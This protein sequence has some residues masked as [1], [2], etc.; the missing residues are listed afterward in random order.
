MSALAVFCAPLRQ[1]LTP[2]KDRSSTFLHCNLLPSPGL[3][4]DVETCSAGWQ[5]LDVVLGLALDSDPVVSAVCLPLP[6]P[7]VGF[8]AQIDRTASG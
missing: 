3:G 1:P 7:G 5:E 2:Y 6:V 8:D 4:P